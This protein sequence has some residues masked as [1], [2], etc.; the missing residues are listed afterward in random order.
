MSHDWIIDL[1]ASEHVTRDHVSFIE[2]HRLLIE[3]RILFMGN[4]VSMDVLGITTYKLVMCSGYTLMLC[5]VLHTLDV[6]FPM[7]MRLKGHCKED[8]QKSVL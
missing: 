3:D 1:E 7:F 8:L 4:R 5:D 6:F 2:Y